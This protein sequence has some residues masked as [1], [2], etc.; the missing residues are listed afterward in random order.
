[1]NFCIQG[2]T[3]VTLSLLDNEPLIWLVTKN[4]AENWKEGIRG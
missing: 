1:L 2:F 4:D 3:S